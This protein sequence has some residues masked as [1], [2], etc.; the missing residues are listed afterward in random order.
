MKAIILAGGEGKRLQPLTYK[1]PKPMLPIVNKPVIHHIVE[2]LKRQ[3][4]DELFITLHYLPEKIKEYL[5]DGKELGVSI[6]YFEE[7]KPL[8]T[9]GS[10]K[11]MQEFLE[12]EFVVISGDA[13]TDINISKV[14]DFHKKHN[15][16]ATVVL[17]KVEYPL[18]YGVAIIDKNNRIN[19]FVEKPRWGEIY[20]DTVN[21]GIYVFSKKILEFII[22]NKQFDFSRDLFPIL[23]EKKLPFYGYITE[24]YWKDIGKF[25]QY[26]QANIDALEQKVNLN[27]EGL[28]NNNIWIGE[29]SVIDKTVNI[30]SPCL[31]GKNCII[32]SN[33]KID[34]YSIIGDSNV[35]YENCN[36]AKSIL[37]E[38]SEIKEN[39]QINDSIV[40]EGIV[41]E[42][43]Y[44]ILKDF[45]I[46]KNGINEN[47]LLLY[48]I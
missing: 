42:Q 37:W 9:A 32:K 15:S 34:S 47:Q 20:S 35:V 40:N 31:I 46:H 30:N 21:T 23:L 25:S 11:A 45:A 24:S 48:K 12:D 33:T 28:N 43:S 16:I 29:G 3:N 8:G 10:L 17:K 2:L 44:N 22:E 19:K 26:K 7:D 41:L 13:V 38:K 39:L 36:I 6:K 14:I 1:K 4:I 18:D 5:K 27:I